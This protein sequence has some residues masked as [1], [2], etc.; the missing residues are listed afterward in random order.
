MQRLFYSV[1]A[2][3]FYNCVIATCGG[4]ARARLL[5][6]D[7]GLIFA[8][9][10]YVYERQKWR[11]PSDSVFAHLNHRSYLGL[12][13]YLGDQDDPLWF[14]GSFSY[15]PKLS[16]AREYRLRLECE[17]EY[18]IKRDLS[19]ILYY[20]WTY[21]SMPVDRLKSADSYLHPSLRWYF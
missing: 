9:A 1:L 6:T 7:K 18:R 20:D 15:L 2:T 8:S 11:I 10:G 19:L 5:E 17:L 16:Q 4:A 13:L 3:N 14:V 21:E 12:S